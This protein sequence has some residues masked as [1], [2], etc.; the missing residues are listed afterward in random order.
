MK[1]GRHRRFE[2]A[3]ALKRGP[4]IDIET[5][6]NEPGSESELADDDDDEDDYEPG[7]WTNPEAE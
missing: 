5:I 4:D 7:S 2:E 3:R 1:K 6:L